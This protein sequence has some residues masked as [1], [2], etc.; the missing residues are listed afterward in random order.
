MIPGA[1]HTSPGIYLKAEG[2]PGKPQLGDKSMKAMRP[3]IYSNGIPY[4]QMRSVGSHR[5]AGREKDRRK[6]ARKDAR[7]QGRMQGRM[8]E[9]EDRIDIKSGRH[10]LIQFKYHTFAAPT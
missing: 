7:K 2:N 5:T 6:D 1:V 3:F 4:L 9:I 10:L 8:K